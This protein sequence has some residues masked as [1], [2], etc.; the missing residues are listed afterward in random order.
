MA[1][2][3]ARRLIPV[4]V[5]AVLGFVLLLLASD[6]GGASQYWTDHWHV[7]GVTL[8]AIER[9]DINPTV[10]YSGYSMTQS[11]QNMEG[12][13]ARNRGQQSCNF[14]VYTNW[15]STIWGYSTWFATALG[16]GPIYGAQYCN[17]DHEVLVDGW[18]EWHN[19][20]WGPTINYSKTHRLWSWV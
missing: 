18:Y 6:A 3:G 7:S 1:M 17:G 9:L 8:T 10:S 13:K 5:V 16:S 14:V 12:L 19:W 11:S 4:V 15:D 2:I 20:T